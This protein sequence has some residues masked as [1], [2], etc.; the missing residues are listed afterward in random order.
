MVDNISPN[1][2]ENLVKDDSST[3][4]VN[5]HQPV[6]NDSTSD[7][8]HSTH[9]PHSE[10]DFSEHSTHKT[11]T[12]IIHSTY[13]SAGKRYSSTLIQSNLRNKRFNSLK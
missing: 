7:V 1:I 2:S 4:I 6:D 11:K 5:S 13:S 10:K 12:N 3:D 9:S 8:I